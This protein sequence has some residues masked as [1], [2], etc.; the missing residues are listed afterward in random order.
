MV[1]AAT[2]KENS[3]RKSAVSLHTIYLRHCQR[4]ELGS[5]EPFALLG[6]F[7]APSPLR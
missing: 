1:G 6:A 7:D 3:G 5:L 4:L 2:S